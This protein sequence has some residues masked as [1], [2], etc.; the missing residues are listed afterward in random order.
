M[1][2]IKLSDYKELKH[3]FDEANYEGYNS[4][5]VNIMMW[6]H[7]YDAYYYNNEHYLVILHKYLNQ[8]I[9]AMPFCKKEY[10]PEALEYMI[11]YCKKENIPFKMSQVLPEVKDVVE[12]IYKDEYIY[13][14]DRDNYDYIYTK[15]SLMTLSGKK[16]QKRRNHYN[17]FINQNYNYIYKEIDNDDIDNVLAFLKEWDDDHDNTSS[18][19]SEFQAIMYLLFNKDSLS[20]KTGCIYIDNKLEAF[21]IA[22][23]LNH[24]TIEIHIEKANKN[25][26]GLY[27]A[28]G[29][30]FLE[31]NYH[32]YELVNREE[33]MGMFSLRKSK[34]NLHPCKFVEKY[35]IEPLN[36]TYQLALEEDKY[37][38][39]ELWVRAFEDET[40]AS[41]SFY[42][43]N[44]Y[45][46]NYTYTVKNNN[47]VIGSLQILPK[48]IVLNNK[49]VDV[50]FIEGVNIASVY[51]HHH[52]MTEL[53][54][55]VLKKYKD[56][57]M[58]LQAYT[59]SLYY[60]FGFKEA[61][62]SYEYEV[63]EILQNETLELKNDYSCEQLLELYNSFTSNYSGYQYRD[64]DYYKDYYLVRQK[65]LDTETNLIIKNNEPIGYFEYEEYNK[66]IIVTELILKE[67][68]VST[69]IDTLIKKFKKTIVFNYP[70]ELKEYKYSKLNCT[71]MTNFDINE[72][73]LF[74]NEIY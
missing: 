27:V 15:Q 11:Q 61:I 28:I 63:S 22:S 49:K 46:T 4:N 3:Y 60:K 37:F 48:T 40:K 65:P 2:K 9:F 33:D 18:V 52:L 13:L 41:T 10:I 14:A 53:L 73:K 56:K 19:N 26:R 44:L 50:Y 51:Q 59:P 68:Y 64:L 7:E 45:K 17:A 70:N 35:I 5:F 58:V 21:T 67:K 43:N 23:P 16:M 55:Y 66:I 74:F 54:N 69:F 36:I 6:D 39:K 25:I 71:L 12:S 1:K 32:D 57:R 42:F 72:N 30:M 62:Y 31:N 47:Y 38:I 29:K 20:I 24:N 8:H 34:M